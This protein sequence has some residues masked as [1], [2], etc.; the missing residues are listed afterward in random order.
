MFY[1][2]CVILKLDIVRLVVKMKQ[3]SFMAPL[4]SIVVLEVYILRF[5]YAIIIPL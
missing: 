2:P 5:S 1:I 3:I 4:S